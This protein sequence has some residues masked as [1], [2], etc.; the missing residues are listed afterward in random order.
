MQVIHVATKDGGIANQDGGIVLPS[1]ADE[2]KDLELYGPWMV[3]ETRLRRSPLQSLTIVRLEIRNVPQAVATGNVVTRNTSYMAS[4]P[5]KR[6]KG[7]GKLSKTV[8]VVSMTARQSAIT[9]NHPSNIRT[10]QHS[11]VK[12]VESGMRDRWE[13][14]G[15]L[16]I[17]SRPILSELDQN[18]S[19]H[20][21]DAQS[22]ELLGPGDPRLVG[23]MDHLSDEEDMV[24][25]FDEDELTEAI[26]VERDDTP[27]IMGGDFNSI[28]SAD[29]RSGGAL[30]RRVPSTDSIRD[31]SRPFWFI[32]AWQEH[33]S[34]HDF[35]DSWKDDVDVVTNVERFCVDVEKWNNEIFCHIGRKKRRF[36]A[37]LRGIDNVLA[38]RHSSSLIRLTSQLR[39]AL[40]LILE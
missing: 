9:V 31:P 14:P 40:D 29:E 28:L 39:K 37:R 25:I 22:V 32:M 3:A 27:W 1:M 11:A 2:P 21:N 19:R 33:P 13:M 36:L 7:A 35:L 17:L 20:A 30:N 12:I 26:G 23:A 15:D 24:T 16:R 5:N 10:G 38:S 34:F 8:E 18:I 6:S 4:N